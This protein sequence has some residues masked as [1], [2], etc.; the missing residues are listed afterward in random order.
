MQLN[1]YQKSLLQLLVFLLVFAG[2][3]IVIGIN[4]P[5][6]GDEAHFVETVRYFGNEISLNTLKSYNEMSTPLPFVLYALWGKY[7]DFEIQT[8]RILSVIIALFTFVSFHYLLFSIFRESKISLTITVFFILNPYMVGLSIF[9]FT[10]MLAILFLIICCLAVKNK[11]PVLFA[12]ASA[13]GL[14]TRQ[15]FAFLTVAAGL[16]Y[17]F[18]YQKT[19]KSSTIKMLFSAFLSFLP[20]LLLFVLWQGPIPDS[21][22]KALYLKESLGF[23]PNSLTLYITQFSIYLLPVILFFWKDI[24]T[25]TKMLLTAFVISWL[26]WVFPVAPSTAAI[27]ANIYTVG[28]FH[29]VVRSVLGTQYEHIFFF[30]FF[31]LGL[32]IVLA[33]IK[34]CYQRIKFPDLDFLLFI[35]LAILTFLLLMPFS[36][37]VWEK[38][39][40]PVVPLTA[41]YLLLKYRKETSPTFVQDKPLVT[42]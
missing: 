27:E 40:L 8:L 29:K 36:Y 7:F 42:A 2:A 9:V 21:P 35:D 12:I 41:I 37:L 34:D 30:I 25:D 3:V 39:F 31:L 24:Y 26:Y 28:L 6:W 20:L 16:Y 14:L 11:S 4:R 5:Y 32:P 13:L 23:H 17:L 1:P 18:N 19:R 10:D 33:I 15:Y 22:R 38:Y